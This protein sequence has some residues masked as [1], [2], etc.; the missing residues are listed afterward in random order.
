MR[1][2]GRLTGRELHG[3]LLSFEGNEGLLNNFKVEE[4]AVSNSAF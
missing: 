2:L 3:K 1:R 4:I